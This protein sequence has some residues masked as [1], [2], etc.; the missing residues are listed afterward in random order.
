MRLPR[1]LTV[2]F[3]ALP[4]SAAGQGPPEPQTPQTPTPAAAAT[5]TAASPFSPA[6]LTRALGPLSALRFD[7][8]Q[9]QAGDHAQDM[10][11]RA[12]PG[13]PKRNLAWPFVDTVLLNIMYNGI[14][15]LSRDETAVVS[16]ST[17]WD[18][19]KSGFEWDNNP[20]MVNQ[21]GHPYQGNNY[22]TAGRA[23]GLGFYESAAVAAFGSATWEFYAENN[24]ASFNDLINT[25][26]GGIAL[27]ETLHRLAWL[28]R[29]PTGGGSKTR[30]FIALAIDPM[31]G[32]TR[33]LTGDADRVVDKPPSMIPSSVR[34]S[35]AGGLM[36]QGASVDQAE[37][38]ASPFFEVALRYGDTR[39]GRSTMPYEAFDAVFSLGGGGDV[40]QSGVRGRLFSQR[41]KAFQFSIFQTY[42]FNM[43][44]AY[45]FG[46]QGVEAEMGLT[47]AVS[48]RTTLWMAGATGV[49]LL[50]AVNSL[51]PPPDD[52]AVMPEGAGSDGSRQ[53][54]Y[55][56]G[57]RWSGIIQ[58][59]RESA[60]VMTI[61]YQGYHV[62]VVDGMQSNH[63]LQ[64]L[65]LDA[66]APVGHALSVG[67]V[68]EVFFRKAYFWQ[69][70]NRTDESSQFRVYVA[71]TR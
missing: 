19:L 34:Y 22:F 52:D 56:P 58:F 69:A 60:P 50:G 32:A 14:N 61:S 31:G 47:K 29:A 30:E 37:D 46:G 43:N 13:C 16:P 35:V 23:N 70:G 7:R 68:A 5:A 53:Y 11:G 66:K 8:S 38:T 44:H 42:E 9:G 64:R 63:V 6:A 45:D 1:L 20:W 4:A 26:L 2:L 24:R 62:A 67:A 36:W 17:W 49:T 15:Q 33:L 25:T 48:S 28:V 65:A 51:L 40:S 57:F 3:L 54:E 55:G 18:N 27:G 59:L 12:C 71:W 39:S 21:F 41:A 10:K